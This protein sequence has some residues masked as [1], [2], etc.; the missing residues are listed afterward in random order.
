VI[1]ATARLANRVALVTGGGRGLGAATCRV[2]AG[3]G[4]IAV[5]ADVR[6]DLAEQTAGAIRAAGGK[7]AAIELD[8][9]DAPRVD[10][11]VRELIAGYGA[12]DVLVNNAGTD[13]TV[14]FEE[15]G[16]DDWDRVLAVNLRGPF[17][18]SRA[19]F[20]HMCERGGGHIV[21]IVS[22]AAKRA[23][24]NAAA[25]HAS[26]WGLLGLSH[27]LHVEARARGVKVTAVIAGGMR[28]PFL[29]DRFPELDPAVLQDPEN[30][31]RTIAFVLMQ[32]AETVVPEVSVLPM[33]ETSWP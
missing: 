23:W 26:K 12:V 7:A 2:L 6:L 30:V 10:E 19:V 15:L 29:L 3:E 22:T 16:V 32:P 13:R 20:P 25:Y 1:A 33:R 31:A 28:T 17:V 27:A 18:M 21:N 4:A 5:A 11:A 24:A 9:T 8:V 14:P